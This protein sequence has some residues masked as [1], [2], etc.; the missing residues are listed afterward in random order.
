M[1]HD[2]P[3]ETFIDAD[4]GDIL[5]LTAFVDGGRPLPS[6]LMFDAGAL[7]F[8]ATPPAD[9]DARHRVEVMATD[10]DG[11]TATG[12]FQLKPRELEP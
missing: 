4:P 1:H 2:L 11:L 5:T 7:R 12:T 6:W 10:V 3:R 9:C 8:T